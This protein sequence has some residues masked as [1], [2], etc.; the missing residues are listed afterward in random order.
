MQYV[1]CD[2][3][4]VMCDLPGLFFVRSSLFESRG[5]QKYPI[6]VVSGL[7]GDIPKVTPG[8]SHMYTLSYNASYLKTHKKSHT[9]VMPFYH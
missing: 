4:C 7:L 8:G 5:D 2:V 1:L 6:W 9:R 3:C